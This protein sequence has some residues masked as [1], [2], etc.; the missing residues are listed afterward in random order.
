MIFVSVRRQ[1]FT[2]KVRIVIVTI[3][4]VTIVEYCST[5]L[6]KLMI[7]GQSPIINWNGVMDI[8]L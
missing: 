8:I 7:F 5:H 2:D 4:C 3:P 6:Q 1:V